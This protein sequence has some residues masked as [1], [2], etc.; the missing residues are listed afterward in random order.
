MSLAGY[1]PWGRKQSGTTEATYHIPTCTH[2]V[3]TNLS[4]YGPGV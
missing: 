4:Q 1:S 2:G 3:P